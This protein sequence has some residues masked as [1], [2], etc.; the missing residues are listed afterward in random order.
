MRFRPGGLPLLF[1]LITLF[2]PLAAEAQQAAKVYRIALFHV[3]LGHVPPAL[4]AAF[5]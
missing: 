3:G 4:H 2:A 1:V 5:D